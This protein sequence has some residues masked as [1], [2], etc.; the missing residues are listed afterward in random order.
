MLQES[1]A[2]DAEKRALI[3]AIATEIDIYRRYAE[4]YGN[5]FYVMQRR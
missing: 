5:V 4:F 1:C 3:E 2:A